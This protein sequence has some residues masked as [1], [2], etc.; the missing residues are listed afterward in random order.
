MNDDNIKYQNILNSLITKGNQSSSEIAINL[1]KNLRS[2]QRDI[3]EMVKLQLI[4]KNGKGKHTKIDI[5]TIGKMQT[6]LSP[7]LTNESRLE[8]MNIQTFNTEIFEGFKNSNILVNHQIKLQLQ[9]LQYRKKIKSTTP[10]L[11]KREL[12]RLII[13][14]SWKSS[15]IEGN[16]YSLLETQ[17]L[18]QYNQSESEPHTKEETTM[19]LNHKK[20]F[21]FVFQ[22]KDYFKTLSTKKIIEL[23]ALLTESLDISKDF[24]A[25]GV[26]ITGSLFRPI[27]NH[28]IIIEMMDRTCELINSKV[29]Y[30]KAL[31]ATLLISYIQPFEDGNKR[32]SRILSNAILYANDLPMLSYRSV[33]VN[34]YKKAILS[35]YEFNSTVLFLKIFTE[36][37][38]Y[39]VNNYF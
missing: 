3:T 21:D 34:E 31:I 11:L 15:Q 32:T 12:E 5:T 39:F 23:H 8:Y 4:K 29:G 10:T 28:H 14:F 18:L 6:I 36:Q 2:I 22:D 25:S 9:T 35:F 26:G 17:E 24:R 19:I 1:D 7:S 13:E 38:E 20:A 37:I 16:T 33:N 27:D 30:E